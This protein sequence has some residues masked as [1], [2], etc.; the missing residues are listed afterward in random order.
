MEQVRRI[1]GFATRMDVNPFLQK[2]EIY[3]YTTEDLESDIAAFDSLQ[4]RKA[5]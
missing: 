3:D 2:Y 5:G 4:R 1:L